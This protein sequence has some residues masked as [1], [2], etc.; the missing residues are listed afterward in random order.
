MFCPSVGTREVT[1]ATTGG[2]PEYTYTWSGVTNSNDETATV[3]VNPDACDT[4]YQVMVVVEDEYHCTATASVT[5]TARDVTPPAIL[6]RLDTSVY[7][8]CDVSVLPSPATTGLQLNAL[9][10]MLSENCTNPDICEV[11][12]Y[13][14]VSGYCPITIVRHYTIIVGVNRLPL[15]RS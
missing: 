10:L 14:D 9:G 11:S 6:G 2:Q 7:Y 5:L 12:S 13:D 3:D 15:P 4:T 1:A 8:G